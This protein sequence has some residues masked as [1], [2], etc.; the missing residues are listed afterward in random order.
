MNLFKD[1]IQKYPRFFITSLL[2]LILVI[3]SPILEIIKKSSNKL[4][5]VLIFIILV[6]SI[7]LVLLKMFN[8]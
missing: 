1:L 5:I 2:G 3:V 6:S 4:W 7:I 8:Y